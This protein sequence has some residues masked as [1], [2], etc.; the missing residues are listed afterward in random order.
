M[1]K[2][3]KTVN[4]GLTDELMNYLEEMTKKY[5]DKGEKEKEE[6]PGDEVKAMICKLAEKEVHKIDSELN[7]L[8]DD[9]VGSENWC[10]LMNALSKVREIVAYM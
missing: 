4:F 6:K 9:E 5:S 7:K 8:A 10:N 3:A 1:A 2:E